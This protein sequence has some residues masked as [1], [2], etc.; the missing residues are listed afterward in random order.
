M[1]SLALSLAFQV[2]AAPNTD[3]A[4]WQLTVDNDYFNFWQKPDR[5]PDFG[6]THGTE[7]VHITP[8]AP[9]V[10][11][12]RVP[13]WL[14]GGEGFARTGLEFSARQSIYAPWRLPADRPYAGWLEVAAGLRREDT[15]SLRRGVLH[16]GVTGPPSQADRVQKWI[17]RRFGLGDAPDWSH[18]LPFEPGIGIELES[19]SRALS[20]GTAGRLQLNAG[21][22]W[23]ARLGTYAI[24][25]RIGMETVAGWNVPQWPS[26]AK[27]TQGASAYVTA[28]IHVD[29]IARDEFLDGPF[30]RDGRDINKDLVV[31]EAHTGIGAAYGPA[32]LEWRVTRRAKEFVDQPS[33]HTYSSLVFNWNSK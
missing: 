25:L 4:S 12:R 10:I 33:P 23:R 2:L 18:E 31:P 6:Y 27:H 19:M 11:V 5:R 8:Q 1:A 22:K 7:L 3:A 30:F 14:S 26:A 15:R 17:H 9:R 32:T 13:R 16:V 24:D 29:A 28:A 21:P 20:S